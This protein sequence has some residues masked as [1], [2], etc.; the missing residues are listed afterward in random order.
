MARLAL[1]FLG[2]FHVTLNHEPLTSF[3]SANNQGLLAY[4]ALHSDKPVPREVL[5]AL[6][7]PDESADDAHNNL[8]QAIYRLRLLLRDAEVAGVPHLLVT[9]QTVQ[10]NPRSDHSLDV[11]R[12]LRAIEAHD[13]ETA[14]AAYSGE[15]LPGFT[16]NSLG[17]ETWLRIEREQLH[18]LAIEAMYETTQDH[19]SA[20][21]LD[22][23]Q[24]T[25][26]RQLDLEPWREPAHRQL[27]QACA[28]AGDRAAALAQF[29]TCRKMLREELDIEPSFET[30]ALLDKIKA[31][32]FSRT[33]TD[34]I[35]YPPVRTRHNL[36]ADTTPFIGREIELA[37]IHRLL[38]REHFRLVTIVGPGGIGKTR[39]AQAVGASL[40]SHFEDGVYF[41]DLAPIEQPEGIA[42]AIAAVLEYQLPDP[43]R[44]LK[45]QLLGSLSR[46]KM[47][48]ILDNFEQITGGAAVASEILLTC[49]SV[50]L[51]I[52]SRE[53]L[54]LTSES[55]YELDGL[56]YPTL[57]SPDDALNYTAVR[58]FVDSGQRAR[59]GFG[60]T[61]NNVADVIRICR[62]VRGM[63]LG[64]ILASGW[65]EILK[66][67][68][69]A[70]EIE[71][72]LEFLAA[73][74]AD[75]PKRQRSMR[76]IFDR[77]WQAL[78]P[79]EQAVMARL[80]IFRGGFT[81]EAAG[82]V[83][84]ANLRVL[85]SLVNK[86]LLQRRAE[87]GRLDMHELLRQYAAEQRRRNDPDGLVELAHCRE[88]A[89]LA[90]ADVRQSTS[91]PYA[92]DW[93][94]AERDNIRRAWTYAVDHRLSSELVMLACGIYVL[95]MAEGSHPRFMLEH[96]WQSLQQSGLPDTHPDMLRLHMHLLDSMSGFEALSRVKDLALD[97]APQV[98]EYGDLDL[99]FWLCD[100]LISVLYRLGDIEA[101]DW[102]GR[103]IQIAL[104]MGDENNITSARANELMIRVGL[105]QVDDSA[106][107]ALEGY[108]AYFESQSPSNFYIVASLLQTLA[109]YCLSLHDYERALYYGNRRL[110]I[111]KS[112]QH[113]HSIGAAST[114]LAKIRLQMG[115]PQMAAD[116]LFDDLQWHLAIGQVWQ[117]LGAIYSVLLEFTSLF[118]S[119][120]A[121]PIVSMV[122]HHPESIPIYREDIAT[123]LPR[124][125]AAMSPEAYAAA[126]EQGKA[127]DFDTAVARM[128]A[129]LSPD[130]DNCI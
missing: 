106:L 125:K 95:G 10:F 119:E 127:M 46:R 69:I 25:A 113:L 97:L 51:L 21:R 104:E 39:L 27:M 13:L 60:L 103:A 130:A 52:T 20:N 88:F 118:G 92:T 7:W 129:T 107:T 61:D 17:F 47:L 50:T 18:R 105:D 35:V 53:R 42:P 102:A 58:L 3:R 37:D 8:R 11:S 55:R 54:N 122:Y 31:G 78:S 45:P 126:W 12:L 114:I 40:L 36:P 64:L 73:D 111:A 80:S 84:G 79:E 14:V 76:A 56:D 19:L 48:L 15:L 30:I 101:L 124:L 123:T 93:L 85:L 75:L 38:V 41:V 77:S 67:A 5:T 68:E 44:D 23:A 2:T 81:R 98:D 16:C 34:E 89:R 62:L 121:V 66:T 83:A 1:T 22:K 9:R 32:R 108:L 29:E 87:D 70:V 96:A 63:P 91:L 65:L 112:C 49:P 90:D 43:S 94:A 26:R 115:L 72:G 110:N 57:L 6:F 24:A 82:N 109:S 116:H 74:I 28:L 4:L 86:S 100:I 33:V 99:R 71:R 117:T 120:T 59:P 128:R